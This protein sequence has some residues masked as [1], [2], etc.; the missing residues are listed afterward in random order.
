[1]VG[2]GFEVKESGRLFY[3]DTIPPLQQVFL[4]PTTIYFLQTSLK[5]IP[6]F[7][8]FLNFVLEIRMLQWHRY[9]I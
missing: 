8:V 7:H 4:P 3:D 1:M 5:N 2:C 6:A 9:V